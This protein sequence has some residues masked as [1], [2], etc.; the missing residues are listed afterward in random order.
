MRLLATGIALT[1]VTGCAAGVG[2]P[3]GPSPSAR[4]MAAVTASLEHVKPFL[5]AGQLVINF[6]YKFGLVTEDSVEWVRPY[7]MLSPALHA[8]ALQAV[9]AIP[10]SAESLQWCEPGT[11]NSPP[12][13]M[14]AMIIIPAPEIAGDRAHTVV[15]WQ[16]DDGET[17]TR[18]DFE[19]NW[20]DGRWMIDDV[21]QHTMN[22]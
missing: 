19:L 7:R 15:L 2:P 18:F 1:F 14:S 12:R 20:R 4:E 17:Q 5:P 6:D 16:M 13:C 21:R 8:R 11:T 9:G 22:I 3:S 10:F